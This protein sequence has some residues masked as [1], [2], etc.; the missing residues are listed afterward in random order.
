MTVLTLALELRESLEEVKLI[1]LRVLAGGGGGGGAGGLTDESS[2]SLVGRGGAGAPNSYFLGKAGME[3][4]GG[5]GGGGKLCSGG[6]AGAMGFFL[7]KV[8]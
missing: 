4:L 6:G 5:G 2:V 1:L 8:S 3:D 7:V